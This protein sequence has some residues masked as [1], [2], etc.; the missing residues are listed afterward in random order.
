M[1]RPAGEF[2]CIV[3]TFGHGF[4][5]NYPHCIGSRAKSRPQL[6]SAVSPTCNEE[7]CS[8]I[9][10]SSKSRCEQA[11]CRDWASIL[12]R[13]YIE[14][15]QAEMISS[16]GYSGGLSRTWPRRK[17]RNSPPHKI[18][19]RLV[20]RIPSDIVF[21]VLR[22]VL[23]FQPISQLYNNAGTLADCRR[24]GIQPCG[25]LLLGCTWHDAN[26]GTSLM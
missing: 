4:D 12:F 8:Q 1:R 19:Q 6:C 22:L 5:V 3:M 2:E 21:L 13:R 18:C 9:R 11:D 24:H 17:P 26:A 15:V 16:L 25:F 20:L 10:V 7:F 14:A 23:A